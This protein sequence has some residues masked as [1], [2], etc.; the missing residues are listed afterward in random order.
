MGWF[1]PRHLKVRSWQRMSFLPQTPGAGGL[2]PPFLIDPDLPVAYANA[3]GAAGRMAIAVPPLARKVLR[4][5]V[6]GRLSKDNPKET[7]FEFA[8]SRVRATFS[9]DPSIGQLV[10]DSITSA[11]GTTTPFDKTLDI[12]AH[13]AELADNEYLAFS[14]KVDGWAWVYLVAVEYELG[15]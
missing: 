15:L 9:P 1:R 11:G 5:R 8:L 10:G 6:L 4:L 7:T 14:A 3:D 2:G 12:P 13:Q